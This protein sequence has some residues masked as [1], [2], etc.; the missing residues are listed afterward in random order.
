[1]EDGDS[2]HNRSDSLKSEIAKFTDKGGLVDY[3]GVEKLV[4][5]MMPEKKIDLVCRSVLAGVVAATDKL[6]C[7]N[8]FVQLKGLP[9]YDEWLQE[10]HKGKIGD[11][12]SP[13]DGDRSIEEFLLIL[14]RALDKLPINLHALQM[15]NIGKSVN[16]LRTHKNLEIQKKARSLVDTW[17]KRVEAEMDAK[18]NQGVSWP[19]RRRLPEV[20]PGGNRQ[21]G[22]SSEVAVKSLVMQPTASKTASVKLV[23]GETTAKSAFASPVS[24]KSVPS[25]TSV[26]TNLKDGQSR[27][28]AVGGAIE[29]PSNPAKD[30]TSAEPSL[31]NQHLRGSV[32]SQPSVSSLRVDNSETGNIS[33]WS[34]T[35]K[36]SAISIPSILPDRAE[37]PFPI[38]ATGGPQRMLGPPTAATPF[39]PDVFRGSVLS[40]SPAVTFPSTSFQ[41][42]V[43]PFGNSFPLPSATFSGGSATYVDASSDGRLCFPGVNSQLL[44][45]AGVEDGDSGHNRSDSL[46][47]EIAKFTDKGGLVDYD[48][49]EKL[50]QL[51]MPE[52]KIDLVCRSVL[53][54]VVAATDKLDCLNWFVQLKGLP[55]Y[56]E[57]LQEVHKGKIGD[58]NSPKDGDRSIEEFLL[59]LLRAL[60]KLPIN[61]HALQMCNIG[62]SVNHL[63]T[64]KNLEIQKKARSL[65][66][67]WKKR[68]EA[69][70]DAKPNQGVSWPARCRLPEVTPGGNRQSGGSSEVA[71]KSL[72]MQPT[73]SKTASVKL[74]PGETTAKSAFAS[75]VSVKSVPSPTSVG[76]NLKDGQSRNYAV[77]GAIELPSNPAKDETSAEPSLVNQHLRGSV[78]SQPS[79]SSLRVDNSETG[80]ISSWSSTGKHSAIS[81]PSILPDRAEQPFPIVATGG[82]QRMLGPPTAATPFSP[83]VFRGSV[84]SSSP[85]VTFPSTSFQYPV[86]PFG[87]S[88]P[89]PSATFS[90]GS[91]TYVDASSDGR[92]CFPG[93]N[94]QLL[95]PAGVED[96][97]SGHNRSD[98][99]KSEIAK[100]T[101]KGGLVDYDGVEKLVQLM[102]PEKK[103]DLVCRS[104]LAGVVAATDK[105][106]CLNWFVQLK[107]LPVYDEWLQEVHKGKIGDGN[108]PKDGDRSIEE[109]LL[110]LLRALDKLPINLHALQMCNIGKSVNHLCTHKN[111]EIQ[112]KA[113]S[114]VDTWKKRVE[115]EMDAKPNQ[116][117]SWPARCRLPE[118]TPGGNRQ[119]GGSSEV[120]VKSLV[121]Q[122]T[123]S[124]TASVKL[125]PGETT[126][127]SAFASP[128]FVKSVPSPTS[129][130]TNLKDGQSRNYAVGGAIELP[131]NPAKDETSAEPSLVNQHLRGSVPSQPTVSSL[132]VDNSETGNISSWSSTGKHSAISIPSILPD[133]AEQPFPIVA[134]GGPQRML[135]PPTAATP[136]SPDVFRGS[137]LSSSPAVTFPSTSFQY[138]VFPFGNSFPLPSATFSGGS[139][140]YVDASSGGR[141]C[142]P[143][144][145]SQLLGPA[146][147]V[148]SH[149]P[150]PYVVNLAD[151][152]NSVGAE[153]SRKWGRQVLDP[154]AG[155][156]GPDIEGRD[157]MSSLALRQ[158]SVASSHAQAEE[159][160]RMY[161]IA[162]GILKRREPEGGWDGCKQSSWQ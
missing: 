96:G 89:L 159:Q 66:D 52:K 155:P 2:G 150:R 112:K 137:V 161:H 32:P 94:S 91:A 136:F 140:T 78:P 99:L 44:G 129:V 57:W 101:D 4:Q 24:V 23:P 153:S 121:M 149:Y 95:G 22:G 75:P 17:K 42:P 154:N 123:A 73:A 132:R 67:T 29:L 39:S 82:P 49:V 48:G 35:G 160:A 156:G 134:T 98:S 21:S 148:S 157:E 43:F 146:G 15:C 88:F 80:N 65:V 141:L 64:H 147:A 8:W 5:L 28:Y 131:S 108:S 113:R 25:P 68:V 53:A 126:A 56:D 55:V 10:V 12:N 90:G 100:F 30:E 111:L 19:A 36:H 92:L 109:F 46:K 60:D 105:L 133:R 76:T 142:F 14:L 7:L 102:M 107:G 135:G 118:V 13:K 71:V 38:V 158:L 40:S 130:G 61:L 143:G 11:G 83:D 128:V 70:M 18:P 120:A 124:K 31:V 122:P 115:A 97:D 16:H 37:Q 127:K 41:Y 6:D 51:M 72:V 151:G 74:V 84:L 9:V 125:V 81:I 104:V 114:L 47:S 34:S 54:G 117:V 138:P 59:I 77:G 33:S 103:I 86:F 145:N 93:V 162:G 26:G 1:M 27:N 58:G 106:D 69:E 20:T 87:N 144:V 63:C 119:S 110:I 3:D 62:K 139:A 152:S 50:V 85:A 45:P 116:G 79:V